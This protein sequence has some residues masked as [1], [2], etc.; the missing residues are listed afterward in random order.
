MKYIKPFCT[1]PPLSAIGSFHD[2]SLSIHLNLATHPPI[3][4]IAPARGPGSCVLRKK[5]EESPGS[6]KQG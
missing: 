4:Y 2:S 6:T 5:A 3:A 1:L